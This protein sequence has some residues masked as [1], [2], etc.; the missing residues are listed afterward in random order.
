MATRRTAPTG[1]EKYE[2]DSEEEDTEE[3]EDEEDDSDDGG[4]IDTVRRHAR[5]CPPPDWAVV[6][7]A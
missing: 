2:R 7:V 6:V 1:R 4:G 5:G 3:S